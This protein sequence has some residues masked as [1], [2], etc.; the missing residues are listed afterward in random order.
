MRR[1]APL[2]LLV[3][4]ACGG[5]TA[6]PRDQWTVVMATDAPVPEFGDRLLVEVLDSNGEPACTACRRQLGVPS[7]W[8]VSFGIVPIPG[9]PTPQ[10]RVRLYRS[11]AAGSDGL[12]EG[13]ALIDARGRLPEPHG[14]TKVYVPLMMKCFGVASGADS[15]CDPTTGKP[16]TEPELGGLPASLPTPGSWPPAA[17]RDCSGSV[18]QGMV[19]IPG[20][21]FLLGAPRAFAFGD[22]EATVPEHVVQLSPFALDVD[23]VTVG[24]VR[25]LVKSGKTSPPPDMSA[26]PGGQY[27]TWLGADNPANDKMPLNCIAWDEASALCKAM[28]KRLPTEAEWEFAAGNRTQETLYPWGNEEG[29]ICAEAAVGLDAFNNTGSSDNYCLKPGMTPGPQPGG[30]SHDMTALGVRNLGGNLTEWVA[31][32]FASY[33]APCWNGET[34]LVDPSCD[35]APPMKQTPV[36]ARSVRGSSWEALPVL[37]QS[38]DRDAQAADQMDSGVGFRCAKSM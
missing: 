35:S 6:S 26:L 21:A 22:D 5:R 3:L 11:A 30:N 17:T 7:K 28:G 34:P 20:G 36:G 4:T 37:A 23:E 32:L 31:D 14:D 15:T 33:S 19:C 29:D 1:F 38:T 12:P 25:S 16:G 18:P 27:C 9:V 10:V 24:A 13:T 8:P 2:L